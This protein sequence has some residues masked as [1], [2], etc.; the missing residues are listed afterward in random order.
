MSKFDDQFEEYFASTLKDARTLLGQSFKRGKKEA[1]KIL[2]DHAE[3]SRSRIKRWTKLL[4][5]KQIRE[6]E[7]KLLVNSQV[8]L[9][10]MRLRTVKVIGKK[11]SREFRDALRDMIIK[12]AI[13]AFL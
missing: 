2:N 12:G 7:Y 11:A 10:R 5:N 13:T 3:N 4:A 8:T 1:T 9:T 6:A